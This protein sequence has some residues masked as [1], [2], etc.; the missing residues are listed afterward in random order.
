VRTLIAL[1]LILAALPA[2]TS[3]AVLLRCWRSSTTSTVRW[4]SPSSGCTKESHFM[5]NPFIAGQINAGLYQELPRDAFLA[6]IGSLDES[7]GSIRRHD[8]VPV[9][10]I[11]RQRVVFNVER[12]KIIDN[13]DNFGT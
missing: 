8:E 4:P 13:C 7:F 9:V 10:A 1:T 6:C 2:S 5:A 11:R 3:A 12:L